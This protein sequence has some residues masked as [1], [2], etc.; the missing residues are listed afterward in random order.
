MS[1][2][3]E[4]ITKMKIEMDFGKFV[5]VARTTIGIT[6]IELANK[7]GVTRSYICD[8]EKGRQSVGLKVAIQIAK[9]AG[10]SEKVA[11]MLCLQDMLD[12]SKIA[13][14]VDIKAA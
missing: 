4:K 5:R 12:K 8:I 10:L 3:K 1:I 11:V 9:Q 14:K 6:Q 7:L 2:K 13:Y